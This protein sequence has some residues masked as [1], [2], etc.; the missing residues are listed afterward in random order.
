MSRLRRQKEFI[1]ATL[2]TPYKG[3]DDMS[4]G[5]LPQTDEEIAKASRPSPTPTTNKTAA[6]KCK[7]LVGDEIRDIFPSIAVVGNAFMEHINTPKLF[8]I[9][10]NK[11]TTKVTTCPF[12]PLRAYIYATKY[13]LG[14]F[15]W[16]PYF[17]LIMTR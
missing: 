7:N 17:S 8:L 2:G 1:N 10:L 3:L 6:E 16:P 11:I 15:L 9:L 14:T 12:I 5:S 4:G 13:L